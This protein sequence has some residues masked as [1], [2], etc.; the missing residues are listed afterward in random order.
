[1]GRTEATSSKNDIACAI[2]REIKSD[3]ASDIVNLRFYEL[4]ALA[5]PA[6]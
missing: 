5:G 1:M 4:K 2:S 6:I 3:L